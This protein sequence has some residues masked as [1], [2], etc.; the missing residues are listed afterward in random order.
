MAA[1]L[2][3]TVALGLAVLVATL[4]AGAVATLLLL[5]HTDPAVN[6]TFVVVSLLLGVAL[7]LVGCLL[8]AVRPANRLGPLLCVAGGGMVAEFA[9][10]DYAYHGLRSH[11]GSLPWADVAGWAGLT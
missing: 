11:P 6:G 7:A 10:R 9:L 2:R 4:G 5:H 3:R 1:R 8:V